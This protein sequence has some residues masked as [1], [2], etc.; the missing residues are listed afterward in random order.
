MR[1]KRRRERR[2]ERRR[3]K[4]GMGEEKDINGREEE[5]EVGNGRE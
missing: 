1:G 4:M 3:G 2:R 5:D